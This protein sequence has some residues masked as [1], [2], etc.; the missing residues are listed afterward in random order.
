MIKL[1][2]KWF[3]RVFKND[4][5]ILWNNPKIYWSH[6]EKWAIPITVCQV[7]I[8]RRLSSCR[9]RSTSRRTSVWKFL[10]DGNLCHV[11]I[12]QRYAPSIECPTMRTKSADGLQPCFVDTTPRTSGHIIVMCHLR[13]IMSFYGESVRKWGRPWMIFMA[14]RI[15][16]VF[17]LWR[18]LPWKCY[19]ETRIMKVVKTTKSTKNHETRKSRKKIRVKT[20]EKAMKKRFLDMK[21]PWISWKWNFEFG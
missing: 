7:A 5:R 2:S 21:S 20:R 11:L 10:E 3:Q 6:I 1:E 19:H 16:M 15:F 18:D 14:G 8:L 4:P 17:M 12:C 13:L 9:L